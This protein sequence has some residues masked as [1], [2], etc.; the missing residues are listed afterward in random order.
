MGKKEQVYVYVQPIHFA[1]SLKL[2]QYCK[3]T[4]L[5]Q[6]LKVSERP[7]TNLSHTCFFMDDFIYLENSEFG[8]NVYLK[9]IILLQIVSQ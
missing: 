4:I 3:S 1:L 2:V 8:P 5:P 9:K 7:T 6:N